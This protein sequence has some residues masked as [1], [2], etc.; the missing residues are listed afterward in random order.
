MILRRFVVNGASVTD[1]L[2]KKKRTERL[3]SSLLQVNKHH[4]DIM[5]PN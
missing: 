5:T 1:A 4:R 2:N 3:I